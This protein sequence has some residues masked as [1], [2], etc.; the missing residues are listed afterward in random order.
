MNQK[1]RIKQI[2]EYLLHH[3]ELTVGEACDLFKASPAT[4]RRDFNLLIVK[5]EVKKTWGGIALTS[6]ANQSSMSPVSYRQTLFAEEK[7]KIAEEAASY[8]KDGDIVI[9]DGGT[10]TFFLGKF[11]SQK[12]IRVITNSILIASQMD[13]GR[14]KN[15]EAE[16]FVT[17]GMMYPSSGLLVGPQSIANIKQYNA[18]WAFLSV[19]GISGDQATNS[20]Q[21]VV[22]TEQAIIEQCEKVVML[23]D[24]SKFG[25]VSMSRICAIEE[26]DILITNHHPDNAQLIAEIGEKGVDVVEVR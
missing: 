23:A 4:I 18:N 8:V 17:G 13:K 3:N 26:I 6:A 15:S 14:Y 9:I 11:L 5:S 10:T 1:Q 21:L 12:K 19:E 2:N 16:V 24:H 22:E 7:S 20:N 25:K